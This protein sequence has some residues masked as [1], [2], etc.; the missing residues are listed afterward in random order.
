MCFSSLIWRDAVLPVQSYTALSPHHEHWREAG[1]VLCPT[2]KHAA[3]ARTKPPTF[4]SF[5]LFKWSLLTP[6]E[7]IHKH[8]NTLSDPGWNSTD[9]PHFGPSQTLTNASEDKEIMPILPFFA[10]SSPSSTCLLVLTTSNGNVTMDAIWKKR[11]YVW[12]TT[13]MT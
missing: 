3:G 8:N 11:K 1:P 12:T 5:M 7:N 9:D 6:T 10:C 2:L 4:L 13:S